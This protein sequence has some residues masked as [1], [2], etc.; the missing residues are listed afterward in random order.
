MTLCEVPHVTLVTAAIG[1]CTVE[2]CGG[3]VIPRQLSEVR[4]GAALRQTSFNS[5]ARLLGTCCAPRSAVP[6]PDGIAFLVTEN[7]GIGTLHDLAGE[8]KVS[9]ALLDF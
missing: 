9:F 3:N 2:N 6:T 1:D 7:K 5:L 8:N 4:R